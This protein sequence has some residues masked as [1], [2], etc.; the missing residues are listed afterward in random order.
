MLIYVP[1]RRSP[2]AARSWLLLIFIFPYVG[3]VAY[4]IFGR[5]YISRWRLEMHRKAS[6]LL[7]TTGQEAFRPYATQP[8]TPGPFEGAVTLAENLGDFAILGGNRVELIEDYGD[9]IDRLIADIDAAEHNVHLLY[10]IFADDDTGR[11]VAAALASAV[12]RGVA[13]RVLMDGLGSRRG[14]RTIGPRMRAQGV[15]VLERLPVHL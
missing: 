4:A 5:A 10:Y 8:Q 13:C 12:K 11:R 2:A 14:L 15:E 3:L 7:R 9:A 1:Q 6:D